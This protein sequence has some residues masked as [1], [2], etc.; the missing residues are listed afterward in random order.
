MTKE[1]KIKNLEDILKKECQYEKRLAFSCLIIVFM[2]S[3]SIF[4]FNTISIVGYI[5]MILIY[6]KFHF[7]TNKKY[8]KMFQEDKMEILESN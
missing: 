1:E 7:D 3:I 8:N 4:A 6:T 2:T 5:F